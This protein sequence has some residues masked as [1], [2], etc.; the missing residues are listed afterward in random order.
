M[1]GLHEKISVGGRGLLIG[2]N[3]N[4]INMWFDNS[5]HHLCTV[6]NN[7]KKQVMRI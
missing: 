6:W 5:N 1:R 2:N 4:K 7:E 3:G